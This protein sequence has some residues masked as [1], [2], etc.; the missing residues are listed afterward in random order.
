MNSSRHLLTLLGTSLLVLS[1]CATGE[2][3]ESAEEA[4]TGGMDLVQVSN[5]FGQLLPHTIRRLDANGNPTSDRSR[6]G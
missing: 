6:S 5:G 3:S 1:G 4:E 2:G